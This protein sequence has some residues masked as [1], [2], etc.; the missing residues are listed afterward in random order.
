VT[1]TMPPNGPGSR[2]AVPIRLTDEQRSRLRWLLEDPEM[3]VLRSDWENFLA[4]GDRRTLVSTDDLNKDQKVAA[5]AWLRQQRHA[6]YR[7]LEGEP[8]APEGWLEDF[9]LYRRLDAE[10]PNA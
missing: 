8:H 3:W 10:V 7:A 4:T 6:L 5:L 2:R 9:D 1:S